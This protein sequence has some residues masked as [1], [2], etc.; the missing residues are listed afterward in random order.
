MGVFPWHSLQAGDQVA[1]VTPAGRVDSQPLER[2]L[3]RLRS[4]GLNPVL[5]RHVYRSSAAIH[6]GPPANDSAMKDAP[7]N[8]PFPEDELFAGPD[9]GRIADLQWALTDPS[10]RAVLIG[11]GGYGAMRTVDRIDWSKVRNAPPRPVIGFS[12]ITAIHAALRVHTD[13][14]SM[15]GV[16]VG[17]AL[18]SASEDET[19]PP[20][21]LSI[22]AARDF[23]FRSTVPSPFT[24][25]TI[26]VREGNVS[27][28]IY[29]GNL[30]I[31]GA[32]LGSAEGVPPASPFIAALEDVDEAPYKVDRLLTQ[33]LRAGWFA[34]CVGVL[35]GSWK[36][37]GDIATVLYERLG[38][39]D[40]PI[41]HLAGFGHGDLHLP[42]PLGIRVQLDTAGRTM[43][44][45][46]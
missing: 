4:W 7:V 16:H 40:G 9:D 27:A 35:S 25:E 29:G 18:G 32:L 3:A 13:L 38:R 26:V 33:L 36:G 42:I 46:A 24:S 10:I 34:N 31:L 22:S 41:V 39:I 15:L 44:I 2:G 14:P 30:A 45:V 11:R 21:A 20:I 17:G 28:P 43:E 1:V 8:D 12:D 19:K 23:L 6:N 5:G 37:C